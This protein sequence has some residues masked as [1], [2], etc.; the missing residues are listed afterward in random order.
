[1]QVGRYL[2][3]ISPLMLP[4]GRYLKENNPILGNTNIHPRVVC[5]SIQIF[6]SFNPSMPWSNERAALSVLQVGS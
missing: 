4:D 3:E 5:L 2:K 1:M 6:E